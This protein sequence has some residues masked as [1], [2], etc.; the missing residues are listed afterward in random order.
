MYR[1]AEVDVEGGEAMYVER[2]PRVEVVPVGV[3]DQVKCLRQQGGKVFVDMV[4]VDGGE[5]WMK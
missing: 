1:T 5:R 3:A 2:G 4:D